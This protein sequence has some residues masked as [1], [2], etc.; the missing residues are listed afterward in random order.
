MSHPVKFT[1]EDYEVASILTSMRNA[2]PALIPVPAFRE[3]RPRSHQRLPRLS[4]LRTYD[5]A[6]FA[7]F[8]RRLHDMELVILHRRNQN[9]L[10]SEAH[11]TDEQQTIL[12]A[13]YQR[14]LN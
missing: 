4:V 5:P 2:V 12:T 9:T 8:L 13:T 14:R 6:E 3:L 1:A 7:S 11:L 10:A